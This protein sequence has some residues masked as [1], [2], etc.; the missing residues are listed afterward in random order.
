M[1]YEF[2]FDKK[3]SDGRKCRGFIE[4]TDMEDL[5]WRLD[6][7]SDPYSADIR[8]REGICL[9]MWEGSV[10]DESDDIGKKNDWFKLT[11]EY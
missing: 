1:L 8:L 2:R 10:E 11:E 9:A 7:F 6:R 3:G 5:F 4:A